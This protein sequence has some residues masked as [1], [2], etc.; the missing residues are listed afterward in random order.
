MTAVDL[1]SELCSEI[2]ISVLSSNFCNFIKLL[3]CLKSFVSMRTFPERNFLQDIT[4][5]C[6]AALMMR[7][8]R[9]GDVFSR[10]LLEFILSMTTNFDPGVL[11]VIDVGGVWVWSACCRSG[12]SGGLRFRPSLV[13]GESISIAASEKFTSLIDLNEKL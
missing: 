9:K 3:A 4:V 12:G 6:M 2:L 11:F 5:P 8:I 10:V 1:L 13:I 7:W